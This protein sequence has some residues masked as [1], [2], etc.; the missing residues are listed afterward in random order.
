MKCVKFPELSSLYVCSVASVESSSLRPYG[1]W[2][3]RLLCSR[4]SPGENTG[5]G[6][7]ALP[8]GIFPTQGS[9]PCPLCLLRWQVGS[10][11]LAPPGKPF[12]SIGQWFNA[13]CVWAVLGRARPQ[14]IS[15]GL[16]SLW[17]T[18]EHQQQPR[19]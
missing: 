11:P 12:F 14:V 5:V 4:D 3:A 15:G 9:V 16:T 6:F 10:L 2:P 8:Q 17:M 13:A 7:H 18:V 1:Q 19:L